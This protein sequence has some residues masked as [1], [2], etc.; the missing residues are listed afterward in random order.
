MT[1]KCGG[2]VDLLGTSDMREVSAR[3]KGGDP[4]D[5]L[6]YDALIYQIGKAIGACGAVL[7]GE[8]D[9]VVLT[10]GISYDSY[11]TEGLKQMVGYLAPVQIFPG[12][13]EMEALAAG[14]LRILRG[15]EKLKVYSGVPVWQ[16]FKTAS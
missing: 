9:S 6:V 10:G 1:T 3:M 7:H 12:E 14:A 16:G 15:E 8:V 13:N 4:F 5:K 11:V 2:I